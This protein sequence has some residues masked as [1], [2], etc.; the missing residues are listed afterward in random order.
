M[1]F[2][3]VLCAVSANAFCQEATSD[4]SQQVLYN[5]ITLNLLPL[6]ANGIELNY[7]RY[8]KERQSVSFTLGYYRAEKPYY[9]TSFDGFNGLKVE[10][11]PR[12][13]FDSWKRGA[14]RIY[15]SP[16]LQYKHINLYK[17]I[18]YL[19]Y[20]GIP[21]IEKEIKERN[22]TFASAGTVGIVFGSQTI[23]YKSRYVFDIYLGTGIVIPLNDYPRSTPSL[24]LVNP[25]EKGFFFKIGL[26][27]GFA[28]N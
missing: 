19:L 8:I 17:N 9:Y 27:M 3:L 7:E 16:Y 15:A 14:G 1:L 24:F 12:F 13:Y 26:S 23:A 25:Y 4:S 5:V 11:Q 22:N 6:F 21:P 28:F 20:E 18:S 2:S 10:I